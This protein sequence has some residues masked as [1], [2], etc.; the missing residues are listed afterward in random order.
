MKIYISADIEGVA[1][2]TALAESDPNASEY[3][4]FRRR[5][6]AEVKAACDGAVAAGATEILVKDAHWFGRNIDASELPGCVRLIRGW[7]GHPY[8]MMQ[9]LTGDFA[10][11]LF[12]GY[13]SAASSGGNPL[14]HTMSGIFAEIKI[15][16][17]RASEFMINS[18]TAYGE[19]VPVAFLSGDEA[20]CAE[21]KKF[22]ENLVTV[23]TM[24]GVGD[25]TISLQPAV[26][27]ER[28][29]AGVESALR[30][31]AQLRA[32]PLPGRFKVEIRYRSP[33]TAFKCSHYP[34]AKLASDNTITFEAKEYFDV[35]RLLA[36]AR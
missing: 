13:H 2:C 9:E 24:K 5:M 16:D 19:G 30:K 21:A 31:R 25:S 33:A 4:L 28:I 22:N 15:N 1:G 8:S 6:T 3:P 35:L 23:S 17:Q 32:Q 36:F 12:V 34:G 29:Q 14:S 27:L 20:L 11:V 7:S 10:A 26:A 18:Y